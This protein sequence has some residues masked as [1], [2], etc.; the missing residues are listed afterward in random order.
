MYIPLSPDR[1]G[2]TQQ[3]IS[4]ESI[5]SKRASTEVLHPVFGHD[6]EAQV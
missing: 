6:L 3:S 5:I 1:R 4:E 2:R